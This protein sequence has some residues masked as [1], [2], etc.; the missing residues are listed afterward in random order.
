[1][2]KLIRWYNQNRGIFW[3]VIGAIALL[4]IIIQVLNGIAREQNEQKRKEIAER[5]SSTNESTTI[6]ETDKSMVSKDKI[7]K[8]EDK[9]N[10]DI[11]KEFV[12][13][14]NN[15]E[16]EKAYNMLSDECKSLLYPTLETFQ[17]NYYKRIFYMYRMYNLE[18]WYSNVNM[19]TYYI[20]YTE[21]VLATGNTESK[22]N[23]ADYITVVNK[24]GKY[25]INISSFVG[26]ETL[27]RNKTENGVT[28]TV[29]WVDSYID[30]TIV[31][32]SITNST[33]KVICLDTKEDNES[34]YLYDINGVK[35]SSFLNENA[36]EQLV[37]YRNIN[38]SIN[39]K[40]NKI[41]NPDREVIGLIASD[42]VL[43][44]EDYKENRAQKQT[45][46]VDTRI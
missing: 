6:S 21:D 40:F 39:V 14:C 43:N 31:N 30:F 41:Y 22:D 2:Y 25:C 5:N 24:D 44:Y 38:N 7:S 1:M 15:R 4:I 10:T 12:G 32:M 9:R 46:R 3:A 42:I 18:N 29:N 13:Y 34:M 37:I 11:V 27:G 16:I 8:E 23:K 35:Y 26:R 20:K 33:D 28:L 19:V 17:E 45:I 36:T